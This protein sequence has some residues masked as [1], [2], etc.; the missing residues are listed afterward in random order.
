MRQAYPLTRDVVL[1]GGG[2]AHALLLRAWGM[3]P[4]PGARLTLINPA[5]SAPYS[6]MLPGFVAGHY[7]RA[8]LEID[9]VRLARH[10]GARLVVGEATGLD[11]YDRVVRVAGRPPIR[12]DIASVDIGITTDLPDL[13]GFAEHGVPAKPLGAFAEAWEGFVARVRAGAAA[14]H[15]AVIGAGVAGVELAMAARHRLATSGVADPQVTLIEERGT[16]LRDVGVSARLVLTREL[17][18]RGITLRNRARAVQVTAQAV[19]LADGTEVPAAFTIGAATARPQGWLAET[20][21]ELVEGCIAVE[22]TLRARSDPAVY[23][24]GDCAHLAADPRPKAGV[25]AVRAAPVL[26]NNIRADLIGSTRKAFR[27]QQGYLKLISLGAKE[28]VADRFGFA[29]K[30]AGIWAWKDRIDR[31]FME[32]FRHLPYR[33]MRPKTPENAAR[34]VGEAMREGA[35]ACGGCAAKPAADV[36]AGALSDL[37]R[38]QR[39]DVLTGAGDDAAILAH[40][41]GAQVFTTDHLRALTED[42]FVMARIAAVHALGDV[43][44]MGGTPQAVLSTV[45]LP[46][47]NESM[48]R[49]TLAEIM[50][51]AG[52]VVRAAGGDIAGGH[53][54]MGAE[55]SLGFSVTGLVEGTPL[56]L[57]GALPGDALV[58]TKPIGTGTVM[59]AEMR[60]AARGD[61]V[62]AALESMQTPSG[63]AS[64]VLA[65]VAHAMTDVT[66]YGLAG[67]LLGMLRASDVGAV[68]DLGAVPLLPGALRL[69]EAGI[70]SSL[71]V[72]NARAAADMPGADPEEPRTALLFDPQTAGG[73]LAAVPEG[74]VAQVLAE[75]EG[76][77]V[78][79]QITEGAPAITLR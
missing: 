54:A 66:G 73:L 10:A 18:A 28:A 11:R 20:G 45:I 52:A 3:K 71:Y 62:L 12:F 7:A 48:Q 58:L 17:G 15:V 27:P 53:S 30:G 72:A 43:W 35:L 60:R 70:R 51:A 78:I 34:G 55:M 19:V 38:P 44:A 14:P 67:H 1:V 64:A 13:P 5:P 68:L 36:L 63:H 23:A 47:M 49:A 25:Y 56:G 77:V 16:I 26:L 75:I 46:Q 57:R 4:V 32:Q 24:V 9:L 79:G 76:A 31:D 69:A 50:A 61:E 74:A 39:A 6:G 40:G 29:P 37:A 2:H 8:Q 65:P 59:A 33:D 21:L 41:N 22:E 42:P